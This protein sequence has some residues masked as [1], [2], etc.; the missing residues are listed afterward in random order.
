MQISNLEIGMILKSYKH[1][2]EVLEEN[3]K[4]SNSK[5]AQLKEWERYFEYHKD[6]NKFIIDSI[7]N[8]EKEK[9]DNRSA[10]NNKGKFKNY[11]KLKISISEYNNKGV[12]YIL[13]NNDIYI[14]STVAGFKQRF[15]SHYSGDVPC[16]KHTYKLLQDGGLFYILLDMSDIIDEELIRMVEREVIDYAESDTG[17]NVINKIKGNAYKNIEVK[18]D[19]YYA[20]IKLLSENG[21]LNNGQLLQINKN[22]VM[23][24]NE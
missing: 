7:F 5:K 4:T 13:N 20:I 23:F 16:M 3:V 9:I 17:F 6:G 12:Y 8:V 24:K 18:S 14:G 19:D 11:D 2:C 10:G 1:L 21:F 15:Q 22:T